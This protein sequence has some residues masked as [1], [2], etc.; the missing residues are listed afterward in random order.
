MF[1][2]NLFTTIFLILA[3]LGPA[4]RL[5][6]FVLIVVTSLRERRLNWP[7]EPVTED[8]APLTGDYLI[9]MNGIATSMKF[10]HLGLF[11][12]AK[13]RR[14]QIRYDAWLSPERDTLAIIGFGSVGPFRCKAT[15]MY[16]LLSDGTGV[17]ST[18]SLSGLSNDDDG[19]IREQLVTNADLYEL[20]VHHREFAAEASSPVT[21]FNASRPLDDLEAFRARRLARQVEWGLAVYQ[22][23]GQAVWRSSLKG[24]IRRARQGQARGLEKAIQNSSRRGIARPGDPGYVPSWEREEE[25]EEE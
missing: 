6:I 19:T 17:F 23:G 2:L 24:A 25:S 18:D 10:R 15:W 13:G 5:L 11:R 20:L 1:R 16:S 7:Y 9:A 14:Y 12:D 22:E 8:S 3:L 21:P 4:I